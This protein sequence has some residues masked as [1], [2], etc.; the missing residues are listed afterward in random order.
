MTLGREI[1]DVARGENL[2][3]L[4]DE[5]ASGPHLIT[6]AAG[7]VRL[8]VVGK[9]ALE[10]KCDPT[11]HDPDAVDGVDQGFCCLCED[12]AGLVGNHDRPPSVMA[13]ESVNDQRRSCSSAQ[14]TVDRKSAS[15]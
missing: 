3:G 15:K 10:L 12:V 9:C 7:S 4:E 1:D 11:P 13:F 14:A 5:H 2:A 8:E 6:L